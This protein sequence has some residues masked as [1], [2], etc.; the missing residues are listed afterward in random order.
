MPKLCFLKNLQIS[1][2]VTKKIKTSH[3]LRGN[4]HSSTDNNKK[5]KKSVKKEK[6][7]EDLNRK[8]TKG[9]R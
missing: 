8:S 5:A 9:D 6:R 3:R 4:E 7:P 1:I 2:D